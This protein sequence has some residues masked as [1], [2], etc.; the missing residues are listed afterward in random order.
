MLATI[1]PFESLYNRQGS[2]QSLLL[3]AGVSGL[4]NISRTMEAAPLLLRGKAGIP[5]HS[6]PPYYLLNYRKGWPTLSDFRW[7]SGS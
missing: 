2:R 6:G 1:F 3:S 5:Q 4:K 7:F